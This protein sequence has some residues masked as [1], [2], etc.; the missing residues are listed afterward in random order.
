MSSDSRAFQAEEPGDRPGAHRLAER[1]GGHGPMPAASPGRR[2]APV[3]TD[4]SAPAGPRPNTSLTDDTRLAIEIR[5]LVETGHLI[6]A[7]ERFAGLV[8]VHQRRASRI[9]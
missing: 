5:R 2:S 9:A 4:S 7:R 6:E 3:G 8:E 1:Q